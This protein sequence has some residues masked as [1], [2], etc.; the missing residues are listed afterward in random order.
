MLCGLGDQARLLIRLE[1][2]RELRREARV[3]LLIRAESSAATKDSPWPRAL[4]GVPR[5]RRRPRR[6]RPD[7]RAA[8]A[9]AVAGVGAFPGW[10]R[11]CWRRSSIRRVSAVRGD[12]GLGLDPWPLAAGAGWAW[13]AAA[14]WA[15]R[16]RRRPRPAAAGGRVRLPS[17]RWSL[18]PRAGGALHPR[19]SRFRSAG[20]ATGWGLPPRPQL[21]LACASVFR[22][23]ARYCW[24]NAGEVAAR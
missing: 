6:R 2:R 12:H 10:A 16:A 23:T 18:R 8:Q 17:W 14:R 20:L 7:R 15:P 9:I 3:E 5:S 13:A 19:R 22:T 4:P 24:R 1:H 21:L 11:C